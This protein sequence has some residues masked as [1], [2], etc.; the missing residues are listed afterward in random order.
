MGWCWVLGG[1]IMWQG[2]CVR[3]CSQVF[4]VSK[5]RR[6]LLVVFRPKLVFT[7]KQHFMY[8]N[9]L[10]SVVTMIV[11]AKMEG[12]G[13]GG[14]WGGGGRCYQQQ[15]KN[16]AVTDVLAKTYNYFLEQKPMVTLNKCLSR[17]IDRQAANRPTNRQTDG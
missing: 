6:S 13:G 8:C 12:R 10:V 11:R 9:G 16:K 15:R 7:T 3:R 17:A 14:G 1:P 4:L 2:F 5:Q